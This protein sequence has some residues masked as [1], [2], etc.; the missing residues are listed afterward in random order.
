MNKHVKI[1]KPGI[2]KVK[3]GGIFAGHDYG[4]PVIEQVIT[5]FRKKNSI[6]NRMSIF[7]NTFIWYK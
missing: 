4:C 6:D 3:P 1:L 7:D 5:N 2:L